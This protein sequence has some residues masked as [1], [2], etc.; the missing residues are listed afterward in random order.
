MQ[1]KVM[2]RVL[3]NLLGNLLNMDPI[4]NMLTTL[5]NAQRVG[6]KRV[7]VP[8]SKHKQEILDLLVAKRM[9]ARY[10]LQEDLKGKLIVSLS[11]DDNEVPVLKGA[12]RLS[13]PGRRVYVKNGRIPYTYTNLG[14]MIVSTPAGLMDDKQARKQGHGGELIC[15]IW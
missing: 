8:F 4:A 3:E 9:V 1:K 6:K 11:Y 14:F 13:K 12:K 10:R 5:L 2:F 7:E 15:A